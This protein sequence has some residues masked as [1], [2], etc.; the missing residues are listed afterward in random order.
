[1]LVILDSGPL[2]MVTN[3]RAEGVNRE[4]SEWLRRLVNRGVQVAV[5][6][7]ADY[8]IR[9]E[10]LRAG[11]HD[12]LTR[13]DALN[14]AVRYLPL[15]TAVMRKA[16]EFWA[17]ARLQGN[18]T[19]ADKALDADMILSAQCE[20]VKHDGDD[21]VVATTNV[22]HLSLFTDARHWRDIQ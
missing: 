10:L 8:E 12:G 7:I 6:E 18:Q 21:A 19:A 16:A 11:R 13:L 4:C 9:R 5:P 1:M 20:S 22:G 17:Q 2:G 14:A 15:T 3:P